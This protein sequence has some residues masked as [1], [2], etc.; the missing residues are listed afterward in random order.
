MIFPINTRFGC[1]NMQSLQLCK[2]LEQLLPPDDE[3]LI[4]DFSTY[5][6]NNPFSNLVL[7]N[8]L[9]RYKER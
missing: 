1:G 8:S 6:E 3:E 7:I 9:R 2:E 4:F 5:G